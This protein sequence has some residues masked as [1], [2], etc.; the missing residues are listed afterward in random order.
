PLT[1]IIACS[2]YQYEE[3]RVDTSLF[4][5]QLVKFNQIIV[6]HHYSNFETKDILTEIQNNINSRYT[7]PPPEVVILKPRDNPNCDKNVYDAVLMYYDDVG[8]GPL[9][10]TICA[11]EAIFRR[12]YSLS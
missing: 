3:F 2:N 12:L 5:E 10:L 6:N 7:L 11:D 4:V 9:G 1:E 8:V